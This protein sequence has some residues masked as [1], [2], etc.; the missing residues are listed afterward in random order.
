METP[1]DAAGAAVDFFDFWGFFVFFASGDLSLEP[2]DSLS[3]MDE[4]DKKA[5]DIK[6]WGVGSSKAL[7]VNMEALPIGLVVDQNSSRH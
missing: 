3:G 6:L 2:D 1:S 4:V 5:L 7:S